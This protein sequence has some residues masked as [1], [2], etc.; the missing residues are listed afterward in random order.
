MNQ[1][2]LGDL[3]DSY[4]KTH[5]KHV[6]EITTRGGQTYFTYEDET[7]AWCG[8]FETPEAAEVELKEYIDWIG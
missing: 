5:I 6:Y 4:K 8:R 2:E 3:S 1:I 7:G